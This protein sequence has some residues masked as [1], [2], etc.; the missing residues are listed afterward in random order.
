M[1]SF[2]SLL[3]SLYD[4]TESIQNLVDSWRNEE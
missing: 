1:N 4:E 2:N 3:D